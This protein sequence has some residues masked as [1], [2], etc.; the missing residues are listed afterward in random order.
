MRLWPRGWPRRFGAR[1]WWN[2]AVVLL[3]FS[4]PWGLDT[5]EVARTGRAGDTVEASAATIAAVQGLLFVVGVA[6]FA[7]IVLVLV[8]EAVLPLL[9]A[10]WAPRVLAVALAV[11]AAVVL[12][13]LAG[14]ATYPTPVL[15]AALGAIALLWAVPPARPRRGGEDEGG[16]GR[17]PLAPAPQ[18]DG[19][20]G[21][22]EPEREVLLTR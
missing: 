10:P 14:A 1:L 21:A 19:P 11:V 4:V 6:F 13:P 16:G 2:L 18:D 15:L 8:G 20:L 17:P 12:P 3:A 5:V 9:R 7:T 22:P